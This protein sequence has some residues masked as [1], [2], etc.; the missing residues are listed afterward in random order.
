MVSWDRFSVRSS[1]F[2]DEETEA[3]GG[4]MILPA[5]RTTEW[6]LSYVA[7]SPALCQ[8]PRL[9][10]TVIYIKSLIHYLCED[11]S[12]IPAVHNQNLAETTF[13]STRSFEFLQK[14]QG[15]PNWSV[16]TVPNI[17]DKQYNLHLTFLHHLPLSK[18]ALTGSHLCA[19]ENFK[20]ALRQKCSLN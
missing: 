18:I 19:L 8:N 2:M 4:N 1:V 9:C 20:A 15:K 16:G 12:D 3:Q 14:Q 11:R 6:K 5:Q 13:N 17:Q 10:S 7:L